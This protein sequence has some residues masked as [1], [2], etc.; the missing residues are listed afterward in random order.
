MVI[1]FD[2]LMLILLGASIVGGIGMLVRR[3][4][5]IDTELQHH[6]RQLVRIE[7]QLNIKDYQNGGEG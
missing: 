3:L 6:G 4:G 1:D 7:T 2:A 5:E